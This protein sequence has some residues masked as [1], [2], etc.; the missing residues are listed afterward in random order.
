MNSFGFGGSNVHV[1]LQGH[2][3]NGQAPAS[4][5]KKGLQVCNISTRNL[6]ALQEMTQSYINWLKDKDNKATFSD[7]CYSTAVRNTAHD[8]RL[9]VVA[10][11][12]EELSES[13]QV[14]LNGETLNENFSVK[15][16]AGTFK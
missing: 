3:Q 5:D 8:F 7:I 12:K 16:T 1:V 15:Q 10:E 11:S 13:L 6:D 4:H 2:K 14:Y 9:S